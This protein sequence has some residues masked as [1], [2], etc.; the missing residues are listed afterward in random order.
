MTRA[1]WLSLRSAQLAM[2]LGREHQHLVDAARR[3][4][5]VH[6]TEMGDDHGLVAAERRVEVGHHPD[7]PGSARAVGLE[8]RRAGILVTGTE[9]AGADR[10]VLDR[11]PA[12]QEVPGSLRP[13]SGDHYPATRHGVEP[14]LAHIRQGSRRSWSC[15]RR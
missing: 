11:E 15:L 6:R 8:H 12:G 3:R 9:R 2:M 14:K 13:F 4:L 10:V 5:G 1:A 7:L